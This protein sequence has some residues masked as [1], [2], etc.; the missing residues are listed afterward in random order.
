MSAV[1]NGVNGPILTVRGADFA[2]AEM[3]SVGGK[4]GEVIAL[5]PDAATIQ[6]YESTAGLTRGTPVEKLNRPMSLTLRPGIIGGIFD[7]IMRPLQ[8]ETKKNFHAEILVQVGQTL[9]EGEIFATVKETE[10]IAYKAMIPPGVSG[11]VTRVAPSGEITLQTPHGEKIFS[12]SQ[13]WPL[14]VPRPFKEKLPCNVP[15]ITGQRVIDSLFPIAKGGTCAI[16]GG[17]G[18]GKTMTQHQ[19]AKHCDA[20]IIIYIGCGERGNEMTEVLEDF[21]RLR[22]PKS[23]ASLLSRTVLIAN[24]SDM[25][26][27]AREASIYTG[28]TLAECYRDMGYDVAIMADSTSRWAEALRELSSRLEEIPAEEGYPAYL[29]ARLAAFYGRAGRVENL[30]GTHGSVTIIGAV[31]PQGADFSEPVTLHTKRFT[32]AFWALDRRLAYARHFP[33]INPTQSYSGY[34]PALDAWFCENVNEDFPIVREKI[35]K[36][37][38][39]ENTLLETV[40]LVGTDALSHD[41]RQILATAKIIRESFTAQNAHHPTDTFTPLHEQ[42][43]MMCDICKNA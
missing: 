32:R 15:L 11:V 34:L 38:F 33:A 40:K 35:L 18:T 1:I 14:R 23:G 2:M 5:K 36:I 8:S 9:N 28:I 3:V 42:F 7:G 12:P 26:V 19:I 27:A 30:N 29:A 6:L 37:L 10:S 43:K 25:P 17:F 39:E 20:D 16:P 13:T 4:P 41:E 22:D 24:T 21:A 31:S